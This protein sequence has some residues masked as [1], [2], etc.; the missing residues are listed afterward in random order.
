MR[1]LKSRKYLTNDG[2]KPIERKTSIFTDDYYEKVMVRIARIVGE[3]SPHMQREMVKAIVHRK[4]MAKRCQR[5]NLPCVLVHFDDPY[6]YR[7]SHRLPGFVFY[8]GL[9]LIAFDLPNFT[10]QHQGAGIIYNDTC[11]LVNHQDGQELANKFIS[12]IKPNEWDIR[13]V[14]FP[15]LFKAYCQYNKHIPFEYSPANGENV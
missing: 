12:A 11:I 14:R 7:Y 9:N 6:P 3:Y 8:T 4:Y 13:T 2:G 5:F 15:E 10:P 1:L